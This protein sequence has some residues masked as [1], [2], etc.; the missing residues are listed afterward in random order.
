MFLHLILLI[1]STNT[2]VK[3]I[4]EINLDLETPCAVHTINGLCLSQADFMKTACPNY[5]EDFSSSKY[6]CIDDPD[7]NCSAVK[8]AGL[9]DNLKKSM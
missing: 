8:S 5:C 1:V 7:I 3:V 6:K 2:L 9:C 4:S